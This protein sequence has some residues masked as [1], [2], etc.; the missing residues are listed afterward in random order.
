MCCFHREFVDLSLHSLVL[1]TGTTFAV[2][3]IPKTVVVAGQPAL[4]ECLIPLPVGAVTDDVVWTKSGVPIVDGAR[5]QQIGTHLYFAS[6]VHSD[7]GS[8]L[9]QLNGTDIQ[10]SALLRVHGMFFCCQPPQCSACHTNTSR[11]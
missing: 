4:L 7:H 6:T 2:P 3:G 5:V 1:S 9:C 8:L 11:L 10:Q